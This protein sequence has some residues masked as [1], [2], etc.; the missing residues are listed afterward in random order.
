MLTLLAILLL[1][2][3]IRIIVRRLWNPY[4]LQ[5]PY[6]GPYGYSGYGRGY[7]RHYFPGGLLSILFLLALDRILGRRW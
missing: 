1:L 7:R 6:F 3:A 5:R 2:V 4:R